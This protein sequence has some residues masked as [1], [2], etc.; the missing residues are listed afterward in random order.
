VTGEL[1]L[2]RAVVANMDHRPA[3]PEGLTEAQQEEWRT[4]VGRM[5][6]GWFPREM[7]GLLVA[8]VKHITSHRPLSALID[9]F[10]ADWLRDPDG[11]AGYDRLL[12]MR[13]RE[14]RSISSL[15]NRMRL[16]QASRYRGEMA[17]TDIK[18][19]P[20]ESERPW[21]KVA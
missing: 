7:H 1:E 8:S 11:V 4:I 15:A 6:S 18:K 17:A 3:P 20:L 21:T 9:E 12:A 5:P 14:A 13:E 19:Q 16:A 10:K 2:G